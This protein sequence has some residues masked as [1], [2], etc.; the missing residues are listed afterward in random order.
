MRT[1]TLLACLLLLFS[2]TTPAQQ[3]AP[4]GQSN[5]NGLPS[6]SAAAVTVVGCVNS[7]N[8]YFTLG[9]RR[10]DLYRLK[11]DHDSLLSYNGKEVAVSGTVKASEQGRTLEIGKMKKVS[12]NC[13]Y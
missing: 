7:I 10:G 3:Q 8:G 9:T 12:E 6:G 4:S 1:S 13:Q 5:P 11:G 2:L